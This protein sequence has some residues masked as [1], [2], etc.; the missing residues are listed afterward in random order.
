MSEAYQAPSASSGPSDTQAGTSAD[1]RRGGSTTDTG[2][3]PAKDWTRYR[4]QIDDTLFCP[5]DAATYSEED[6]RKQLAE[7]SGVPLKSITLTLLSKYKA[8][9]ETSQWDASYYN[10]AEAQ[11]RKCLSVEPFTANASVPDELVEEI[12]EEKEEI[13]EEKEQI[14]TLK[15]LRGGLSNMADSFERLVE[16]Y[17]SRM[18]GDQTSDNGHNNDL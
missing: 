14:E 11:G 17:T 7:K 2:R 15:R 4:Y 9:E 8:N 10:G 12:E 18:E 16:I 13:E 3:F 5:G 1:E 6:V